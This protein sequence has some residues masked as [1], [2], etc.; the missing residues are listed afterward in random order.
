MCI[1]DR[2]GPVYG[3]AADVG[4][5]FFLCFFLLCPC[6][7]FFAFDNRKVK[8]TV[9]NIVCPL[10]ILMCGLSFLPCDKTF[11]CLFGTFGGQPNFLVYTRKVA[12]FKSDNKFP[13]IVLT[14]LKECLIGIE[15]I[16]QN[17]YWQ[18]WVHLF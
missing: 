4:E 8:P 7:N 10:K 15:G 17:Y 5:C 11:P 14:Y 9:F 12:V 2:I 13:S 3:H 18:T 1:R 6:L 16:G